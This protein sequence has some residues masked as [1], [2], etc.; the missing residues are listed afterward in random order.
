MKKIQKLYV[1]DYY[2]NG[3]VKETI[4][5]NNPRPIVITKSIIKNLSTRYKGGKLIH[6]CVNLAQVNKGNLPKFSNRKS[7]RKI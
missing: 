3:Q 7:G 1:I 4:N 2:I 5:L 6:R